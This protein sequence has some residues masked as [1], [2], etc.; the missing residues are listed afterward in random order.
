MAEPDEPERQPSDIVSYWVGQFAA[1][2]D[3]FKEWTDRCKKIVRRYRAERQAKSNGAVV[4]GPRFNS[5]WANVQTLQPAIY[6]KAPQPIVE[7]RYRDKDP[8]ARISSMTLERACEVQIEVGKL[9]PAMQKATLDYLLCGR[10]TLWERYEPTFGEPQDLGDGPDDDKST[11][12]KDD[13]GEAPRPVT[14]EKSCTDHI[15]WD[16]FKHSP[17][18]TWDQVWWVAKGEMLTRKE[19]RA[20]FKA[21][22]PQSGK[23]IADLVPM[24]EGDKK[25]AENVID[26]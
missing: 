7:R 11:D 17:V 19:M 3:E 21:K 2:D 15:A 14:Y 10:A 13:Q 24:R 23:L 22:D 8:L 16:K 20:R 9:H 12:K 26:R 5:L 4:G 1:Y 6:I 18:S 25:D